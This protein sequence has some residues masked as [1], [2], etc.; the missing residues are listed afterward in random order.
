MGT[1]L[2]HS[3]M[4]VPWRSYSRIVAAIS[5]SCG[6]TSASPVYQVVLEATWLRIKSFPMASWVPKMLPIQSA[7]TATSIR[8][9]FGLVASDE[10]Y[11]DVNS[12]Q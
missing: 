2:D 3:D 9:R 12:V 11:L 5:E 4:R 6:F 10:A 7:P 8:I 1:V